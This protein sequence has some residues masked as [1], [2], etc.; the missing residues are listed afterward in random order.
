MK[1]R[2]IC[3]ILLTMITALLT[4]CSKDAGVAIMEGLTGDSLLIDD[5]DGL[6]SGDEHRLSTFGLAIM[7]II[8][9]II[10]MVV[11]FPLIQDEYKKYKLLVGAA[12]IVFGLMDTIDAL[13]F[14]HQYDMPFVNPE[15][16]MIS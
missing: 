8:V 14:L 11:P 13:Y 5:N 6:Y 9:G 15:D 1:K 12:L 16:V 4:G 2:L 7:A 10:I 3:I